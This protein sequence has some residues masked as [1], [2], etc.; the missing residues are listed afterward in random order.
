[1][2]G[3]FGRVVVACVSMLVVAL[4][5]HAVPPETTD[6]VAIAKA[7]EDTP[8]LDR[9]SAQMKMVIKD[10]SGS[11]RERVVQTTAMNFAD[12][13]KQMI[14]FASPADVRNTGLLTVDYKA[15]TKTDDQWLYLPALRKSTRIASSAK[16]GSFMGSDLSFA[17]MTSQVIEDYTHTMIDANAKVGS[18]ACWK[19]EAIPKTKKAKDET[20]YLKSVLWISKEKLMP[21]QLKHFIREGKKT[22]LMK[23]AK[24][25]KLG[26]L[27][28]SHKISAQTRQGG[29][30]LS[31]TVLS[32][33]NVKFDD[34]GITDS[35]F[36]QRR[37][38]RGL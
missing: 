14:L 5:A 23:F 7:M 4:P 21:L 3:W 36:S 17:D 27:W 33:Q 9:M 10:A 1:M 24:Y 35:E 30:A 8:D 38:E 20:G 6:P 18:E 12:S 26:S 32:F 13:R 11:K 15:G 25:K 37:L 29:K 34:A 16:S 28:F 19:I 22:K 31:T 2:T